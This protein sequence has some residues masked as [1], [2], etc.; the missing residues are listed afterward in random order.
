MKNA[1]LKDQNGET[2][3]ENVENSIR[4]FMEADSELT[5]NKGWSATPKSSDT[6]TVVYDFNNG[7]LG[8]TQAMWEADLASKQVKYVNKDGMYLSWVPRN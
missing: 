4:F 1:R 3:S 6:F 7:K 2:S 8:E 5:P